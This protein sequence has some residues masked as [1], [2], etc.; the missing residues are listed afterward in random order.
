VR[1]VSVSEIQ[2]V[3][4]VISDVTGGAEPRRG[5]KKIGKQEGEEK[6][7]RGRWDLED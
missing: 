1:N 4:F 3:I 6:Y 7:R 5:E 2:K